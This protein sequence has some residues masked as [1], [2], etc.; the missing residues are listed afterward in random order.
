[1]SKNHSHP[2]PRTIGHLIIPLFI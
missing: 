2:Y 1:M